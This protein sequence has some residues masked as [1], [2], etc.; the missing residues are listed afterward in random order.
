MLRAVSMKTLRFL[1]S[2]SLF[3]LG[4]SVFNTNGRAYLLEMAN[5]AAAPTSR[6]AATKPNL[7][8]DF[9]KSIP[10]S[11][12]FEVTRRGAVEGGRLAV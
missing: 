6:A 5:E 8:D 3:A 7:S 4:R 12:M 11:L 2:K 10:I 1:E 9:I